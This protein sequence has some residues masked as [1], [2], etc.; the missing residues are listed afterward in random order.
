MARS[1]QKSGRKKLSRK[2]MLRRLS[3]AGDRRP[4]VAGSPA[5]ASGTRRDPALRQLTGLAKSLFQQ[6]QFDQALDAYRRVVQL[7]PGSRTASLAIAAIMASR[8]QKDA[9]QSLMASYF[10]KYPL[11][12]MPNAQDRPLT[13]KLRGFDQTRPAIGQSRNGN[14]KAKL[15][16]GHFTTQYLLMEPDFAINTFTIANDNINQPGGLPPCDLLLNTISEPDV[17][18]ASLKALSRYLDA[19]P[20]T[21]VINHPDRVWHTAR[22]RNYDRLAETERVIFPETRR[23]TFETADTREVLRRVAEL[24]VSLPFIIREAGTQTGRSTELCR[25]VYDLENYARDGLSGTYFVIA[26]RQI[27]WKDKYFRKLRL[28]QID[29][30]FYPVVCHLDQVWLVHGGNRKEIM[31]NDDRLMAEERAFLQDWRSYVGPGNADNLYW[32]AEKTGMEFFGV[33][34]TIDADNQIFI[35]E[36]NAAMRH[37]FDHAANFSYKIEHDLETS[38]AFMRMVRARLPKD[39]SGHKRPAPEAPA[40]V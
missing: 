17:E 1:P 5:V 8:N 19:H 37:S 29:G 20:Q 12:N 38:H 16:G 21:S 7:D 31:R 22:D 26:Y 14:Y 39:W 10:E 30:E 27:L 36:L 40:P 9:A 24:G 28:F 4:V 2:D 3:Q 33:D 32:L 25:S 34:F 15:R 23:I 13:L 6:G 35:Y 11:D 18:D